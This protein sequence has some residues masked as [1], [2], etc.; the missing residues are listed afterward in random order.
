MMVRVFRHF[1]PVS[2]VLLAVSEVSIITVAWYFYLAG[3]PFSVEKLIDV[4]QSPTLALALAA[5]GAM[6]ITGLYNDKVFADYRSLAIHI[7]IS[8]IFLCPIAVAGWLYWQHALS[9]SET[10]WQIYAKAALSW[11]ACILVTRAVFISLTD[12]NLFKA[13]VV[14]LGTGEKAARI[15]DI[16]N[17]G[18]NRYFLP[19]AYLQLPGQRPKFPITPID[20]SGCDVSEIARHAH[21]LRAKE[22]VVATDDRRGLPVRQLLQCRM[23]GIRVIDYLDF[24]ERETMCVDLQAVQPGWFVFSDGFRGCGPSQI[25]KR[26][27]DIT[28][29]VAL[30]LFVM[31]LMGLTWLLIVLESPGHALYRQERVGLGGHPF[32]LLK[33]R[34]MRN[35]AESNGKAQWAT[36]DDPRVTRVG[37]IIRKVRIDELPQL[38][39]VLRGDMSFVGPRPERPVFVDRFAEQIPYYAERH[40]VRPGITGWAQINYPYGASLQDARNK[41]S[42]DLYYIKNYG[43]FLDLL[44]VLQTFRVILFADGSR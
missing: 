6:I 25:F 27:F 1:V 10:L 18:K 4:V 37:R 17:A 23:A 24:L 22:V 41:L 13:R 3:N 29:S 7:A 33:F 28:L 12:L 5:G 36:T 38:I 26:C 14:V 20:V 16:V 30:L 2:I 42:Y 9:S 8:L 40:C 34:S 11:L 32:V 39:N 44:I 15:A 43:S 21:D 19:V 35:D 31:P